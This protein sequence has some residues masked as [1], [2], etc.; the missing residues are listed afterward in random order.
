[1]LLIVK[2]SYSGT[3]LWIS[4]IVGSNLVGSIYTII[5]FVKSLYYDTKLYLLHMHKEIMFAKSN[6]YSKNDNT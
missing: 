2:T 5:A 3:N 6:F 4:N 1:V